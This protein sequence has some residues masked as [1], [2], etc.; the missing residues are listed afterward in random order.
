VRAREVDDALR[1]HLDGGGSALL[2]TVTVAHHRHEAL[3]VAWDRL[4]KAYTRAMAGRGPERLREHGWLGAIRAHEVTHGENGWHPHAH[5]LWFFD[6]PLDLA[7]HAALLVWWRERWCRITGIDLNEHV[8]DVRAVD[9]PDA[10]AVAS[11]LV[12]WSAGAELARADAKAGR[13]SR[14]PMQ[15]LGDAAD[16]DEDAARLWREFMRDSRGRRVVIWSRGL[17]ARLIGED[18]EVTDEAIIEDTDNAGE[19]VALIDTA[20]WRVLERAGANGPLLDHLDR[21]GPEGLQA[22]L[23]CLHDLVVDDTGPVLWIRLAGG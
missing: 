2:V 13:G 19:L 6:R 9:H 21:H 1:R 23:R 18:A 4:A 17:R 7:E 5:V 10:G 20:A 22:A 11:Y 14:S 12:G 16:G 8:V 15:L 3:S